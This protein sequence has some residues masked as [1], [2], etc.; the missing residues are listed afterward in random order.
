MEIFRFN[1][2]PMPEGEKRDAFKEAVNNCPLCSCHLVFQHETDYLS[3]KLHEQA[4]CEKCQMQ[5]REEQFTL[6]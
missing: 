5:I 1:I 4:F 6:Q 2:L 3:N